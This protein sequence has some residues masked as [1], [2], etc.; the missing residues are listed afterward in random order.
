MVP[1]PEGVE[2][3]EE[4]PKDDEMLADTSTGRLGTKVGKVK[5]E[6]KVKRWVH[7]GAQELSLID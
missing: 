2:R 6:V 3:H 4:E 1:I 5:I 7:D